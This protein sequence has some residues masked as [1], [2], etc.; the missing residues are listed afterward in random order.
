MREKE[1]GNLSREQ[2]R[3][4]FSF[5]YQGKTEKSDLDDLIKQKREKL[6][7]VLDSVIPWSLFYELPYPHLAVFYFLVLASKTKVKSILKSKDPAQALFDWANSDPKPPRGFNKWDT[8]DMGIFLSLTMAMIFNIQSISMFRQ[9]W[10][11]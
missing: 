1:F 7:A 9:H 5:L 2:V 8:E 4:T 11:I 10:M 3:E 6:A